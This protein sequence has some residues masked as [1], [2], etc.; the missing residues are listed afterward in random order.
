MLVQS[1]PKLSRFSSR[2]CNFFA[3]FGCSLIDF[4]RGLL[5]LEAQSHPKMSRHQLS[6][7]GR[8]RWNGDARHRESA[9]EKSL[10]RIQ[11]S[12]GDLGTAASGEWNAGSGRHM[13]LT[14][15]IRE[16]VMARILLPVS[17]L[18]FQERPPKLWLRDFKELLGDS[19]PPSFADFGHGLSLSELQP[20]PR[21]SE[22]NDDRGFSD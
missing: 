20:C 5:Q 6:E 7:W 13:S 16:N 14:P 2:T 10:Q 21:L 19:K 9:V 4:C 17:G 18:R 11:P 3:G 8:N 22:E 15:I 12:P 1:K